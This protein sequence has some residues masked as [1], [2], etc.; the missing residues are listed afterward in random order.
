LGDFTFISIGATGNQLKMFSRREEL[1]VKNVD[2]RENEKLLDM[3]GGEGSSA[4][5]IYILP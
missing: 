2:V 4:I 5:R 1:L 3:D